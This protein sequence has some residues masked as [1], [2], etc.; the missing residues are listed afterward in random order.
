M[1]HTVSYA[2]KNKKVESKQKQFA[3]HSGFEILAYTVQ[4]ILYS[5]WPT[6][7]YSLKLVCKTVD[8]IPR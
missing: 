4:Y 3:I 6:A 8:I 2:I 1:F 7:Y 5:I